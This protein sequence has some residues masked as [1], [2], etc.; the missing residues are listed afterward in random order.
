MGQSHGGGYY[1]GAS[2]NGIAR[3]DAS[4]LFQKTNSYVTVDRGTPLAGTVTIDVKAGNSQKITV[5]H[6]L[7]LAFTNWENPG[8]LSEVYVELVN[9]GSKI[10]SFPPMKWI[11]S[12]TGNE[13]DRLSDYLVAMGRSPAVL[14]SSGTERFIFWTVNGGTIINAKFV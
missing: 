11:Q 13:F 1:S 12:S 14:K 8:H 4:N 10:F 7:T 6:D 9:P 5:A 2:A 3:V